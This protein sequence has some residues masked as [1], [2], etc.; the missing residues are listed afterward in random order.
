MSV[1]SIT[2]AV[3]NVALEFGDDNARAG[4][5]V[6]ESFLNLFLSFSLL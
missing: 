3:S 5:M 6:C 4:A 1:E 2:Q